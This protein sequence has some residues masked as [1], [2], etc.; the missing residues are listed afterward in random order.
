LKFIAVYY[1][2]LLSRHFSTE[3]TTRCRWLLKKISVGACFLTREEI[4]RAVKFLLPKHEKLA[5]NIILSIHGMLSSI[6]ELKNAKRKT[7]VL[8]I[9]EVSIQNY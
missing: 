1:L 2:I 6:N 3:I 5:N 8:V 9:D 4:A 7:L